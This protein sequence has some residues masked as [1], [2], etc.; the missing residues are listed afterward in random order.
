MQRPEPS[1]DHP[2]CSNSWRS[3]RVTRPQQSPRVLSC[4]SRA[5]PAR[6]TLHTVAAHP[7][8]SRALMAGF[9]QAQAKQPAP[10]AGSANLEIAARLR[11]VGRTVLTAPQVTGAKTGLCTPVVVR[12]S[13]AH[14]AAQCRPPLLSATSPCHRTAPNFTAWGNWRAS[15]GSAVPRAPARR[16]HPAECARSARCQCAWAVTWST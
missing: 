5:P 3:A 11:P 6:P 8:A 9:S 14:P 16:A 10:A 2:S 1:S 7:R 4:A 13:S 12:A 15:L